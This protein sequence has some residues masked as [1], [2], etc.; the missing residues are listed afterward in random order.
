MLSK[1]G[2][3]YILTMWTYCKRNIGS[4]IIKPKSNP[5]LFRLTSLER[6]GVFVI[7]P[8]YIM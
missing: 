8:I 6:K 7:N 3:K 4:N 5:I 1:K 2:I